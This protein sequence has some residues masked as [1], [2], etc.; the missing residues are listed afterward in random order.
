M[1]WMNRAVL[2]C[3]CMIVLL[4]LVFFNFE[5]DAMSEIDNRMLAGNPFAENAAGD[6]TEQ[7][8]SYVNDRIGFRDEMIL[9]YTVLND[10]LFGK[11][12]HPSYTYGTDGYVFGAGI[13]TVQRYGEFHEA[14]ADAMKQIQD[15]CE[16]RNVPFLMVFEPAKPGILTEYLEPGVCYNHMWVDDFLAALDERNVSYVDN[17]QV[18]RQKTEDGEVVFNQKYDANHWNDLGAYYGT[19]N[20]IEAM[21]ERIPAVHVTG[22]EELDISEKLE[23]SLPVSQFPIN[24]SVPLI[25]ISG[26][27]TKSRYEQYAA[28]LEMD[29]RYTDFG[30]YVNPQRQAEGAPRAL[31]FQGSYMNK[32]G[33][34]YFM[35]AF[36]EYIYVHDYQNTLNLPYYFNIFQPDCV[37]VEV[38]EYT[39][40]DEYFSLDTMKKMQFNPVLDP[41]PETGANAEM[42]SSN[43][44]TVEQGKTLTK[45]T[46]EPEK[47]PQYAWLEMDGAYDFCKIEETLT[48]TVKTEDYEKYSGAMRIVVMDSDESVREYLI[49]TD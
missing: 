42:L 36:G 35:N 7:F 47:L 3:F 22:W 33:Y 26:M 48:V 46:W 38:A 21:K 49:Q 43:A 10:R 12:V 18:L 14:F 37:I 41:V 19:R 1:K 8:E 9:S 23:T 30:Y 27:D 34:K 5:E 6:L 45:L 17:T 4:P 29:S 31:V 13:W 39:L 44:I 32:A 11:M 24:E 2:L 15:Y 20:A 25:E 28:E 16:V 40:S